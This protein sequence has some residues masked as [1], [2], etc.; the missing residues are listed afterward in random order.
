MKLGAAQ[1]VQ[2]AKPEGD[3]VTTP[4][5][6]LQQDLAEAMPSAGPSE[7]LQRVI[8]REAQER[9]GIGVDASEIL[10]EQEAPQETVEDKLKL[11]Q[12]PDLR[13]QAEQEAAQAALDPS[14][15]QTRFE[16]ARGD[17]Y[18]RGEMRRQQ[19]GMNRDTD[20]YN[21]QGGKRKL[22]LASDGGIFDRAENFA[23]IILDTSKPIG[24]KGLMHTS[25]DAL[26]NQLAENSKISK[27]LISF[28][29]TTPDSQTGSQVLNPEFLRLASL[30]TEDLMADQMMGEKR[31]ED[32]RRKK[33]NLDLTDQ[34]PPEERPSF[35]ISKMQRNQELGDRV[36]KEWAKLT[37][38]DVSSAD[39]DTKTFLGDM[40]KELY[41]EVNK[42]TP[43]ARVMDR[44]VMN[45]VTEGRN[46]KKEKEVE[47]VL[48]DLGQAMMRESE[49]LR[50]LYFPKEHIDA[51]DS[52]RSTM[53]IRVSG[54]IKNVNINAREEIV[55]AIKTLESI[56]HMVIPR[57]EKILL[58]TLLPALANGNASPEI[59]EM[60]REIN[61]FGKSKY[62]VFKA[63][64]RIAR[65][66]NQ[67]FNADENLELLKRSIAQSLLGVAKHRGRKV[68]LTYFVQAFNGR[69]TAEQSH[70]NPMTSK[71]VRFVTGNP[72][73]AKFIPGQ[74]S[75]LER[76]L[77]EMYSMMIL[78]LNGVDAGD[79]LK[80]ERI[81]MFNEG[82][83]NLISFGKYLKESL[84]N[85]SLDVDAISDAIK[86]GIPLDSPDFPKFQGLQIDPSRKKLIEAISK[87]GEDGLGLIDGL[88]DLYEYDQVLQYNKKNPNSPQQFR[89]YYNAYIDGKTNG[90][91]TNGMQLGL[92]SIAYKTGVLRIRGSIYAVD[93]NEDIR[94]VLAK[95]L[96]NKLYGTNVFPPGTFNKYGFGNGSSFTA[97]A[98]ALFNNRDLNKGTTMTFGYGK[99]L[100]SFKRDLRNYLILNETESIALAEELKDIDPDTISDKDKVKM[101]LASHYQTLRD[102][103]ASYYQGKKS[104][105]DFLVN[106]LFGV[107][108]DSIV[109]V[110]TP[111]GIKARQMMAN[112]A[113]FHALMGEV[114]ELE[115]P[116]GMPIYLGGLEI[117]KTD[118]PYRRDYKILTDDPDRTPLK[119][120]IDGEET[121]MEG[122]FV[123]D[124][125][126]I[127]YKTRPTAATVKGQ[128]DPIT[129][130]GYTGGAA[131]G[132]SNPS[133]VQAVDAATVAKTFSG[134][135]ANKLRQASPSG[136]IYGLQIY[137][138]FKSDV[139]N[140]DVINREVNQNW[141]NVNRNFF[142]LDIAH[143]KMK[144]AQE[145][146]KKKTFNRGDEAIQLY[147]E[148][149][150]I[151]D[152]L[153]TNETGQYV[154]LM[155][156]FK[157]NITDVHK[158]D[159]E[160]RVRKT[161]EELELEAYETVDKFFD[162]LKDLKVQLSSNE[163][164]GKDIFLFVQELSNMI[165]FSEDRQQFIYGKIKP[166]RNNLF[167]KV[168]NEQRN[169]NLVAQYH[170]H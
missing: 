116:T 170:A 86:K 70:F 42:G 111:D 129:G 143:T 85:T 76:N 69:L 45:S 138:A 91:A 149:R 100:D 49:A 93:D 12:A 169:N 78:K 27:M 126:T 125:A 94:D 119:R 24:V 32:Q 30:V 139:H 41:Y 61:G 112:M 134:S 146:F 33:L 136:K 7:T 168:D 151:R 39:S 63:R 128:V 164:K 67:D 117:I 135:S 154:N 6:A 89:T 20:R 72:E 3:A 9:L 19:R 137:D 157:R 34:L 152:Y 31:L 140:F 71:Q 22:Q 88:I 58:A 43:E 53:D 55:E 5:A 64:E 25:P 92:E 81:R 82:Y 26:Q 62:A 99:E 97:I 114:F 44:I 132:G 51:L 56:P 40:L 87:K 103:F 166:Q 110:I 52:P 141:L 28:N 18:S 96:T 37:N 109:D 155:R 148:F 68:H 38:A 17:I 80:E 36:L 11:Y 35:F 50:K 105:E 98:Y 121:V 10:G 159:G 84:D 74:D 127:K 79:V 101:Q 150:M 153:S 23:N 73:V 130:V 8:A 59:L 2:Q 29:A 160:V 13:V 133:S 131:I 162:K 156:F 48:T 142:Y 16:E 113:I 46:E 21:F 104:L 144:V 66:D 15:F 115:T 118:D 106:D 167:A 1:S 14:T 161:K 163:M 75:R 95:N 47:F 108:V 107:Y 65:L 77:K 60:S 54:A 165:N 124:V 120:K 90:L 83:Q 145:A 102:N 123:R 122:E 158:M 4:A 57:R 147:P